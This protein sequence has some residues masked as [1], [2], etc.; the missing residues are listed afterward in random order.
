MR[1]W[2]PFTDCSC[3]CSAVISPFHNRFVTSAKTGCTT[4]GVF[5][6]YDRGRVRLDNPLAAGLGHPGRVTIAAGGLQ[7]GG[8]VRFRF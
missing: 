5:T 4:Y 7:V 3:A 1:S 2:T 6:K 8:G